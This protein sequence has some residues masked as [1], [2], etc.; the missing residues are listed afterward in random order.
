MQPAPPLLRDLQR[1]PSGPCLTCLNFH[2]N[3]RCGCFHAQHMRVACKYTVLRRAQLVKRRRRCLTIIVE[4]WSLHTPTVRNGK[5]ILKLRWKHLVASSR[6][7]PRIEKNL[8]EMLKSGDSFTSAPPVISHCVCEG[9]AL[10]NL[11]ARIRPC[12]TNNLQ[13]ATF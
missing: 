8:K 3:C 6:L 1:L 11:N 5:H 13:K 10:R 2:R 12:S 9:V 7:T 4:V